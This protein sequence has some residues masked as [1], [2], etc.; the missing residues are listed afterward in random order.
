MIILPNRN[1]RFPKERTFQGRQY[2]DSDSQ[3]TAYSVEKL[4]LASGAEIHEEFRLIL[5]AFDS[6]G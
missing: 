6:A 2:E 5:R 4:G 1:D 3:L